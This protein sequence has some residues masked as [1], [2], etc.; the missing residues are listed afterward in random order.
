MNLRRLLYLG[1]G[2]PDV[3]ALSLHLVQGSS[4][5]GM[6]LTGRLFEGPTKD[7]PVGLYAFVGA[8]TPPQGVVWSVHRPW[9][10][11]AVSR[12]LECSPDP[13]HAPPEEIGGTPSP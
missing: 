6:V 12:G 1:L 10:L 11:L 3:G 2:L 9:G 4:S 5:V 8:V 7:V 13:A